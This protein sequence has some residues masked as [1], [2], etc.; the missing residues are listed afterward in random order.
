MTSIS[1]MWSLNKLSKLPSGS[2]GKAG[3]LPS[4]DDKPNNNI[5]QEEKKMKVTFQ[6]EKATKNTIRFEEALENALDAPKIGTL[7]VPKSTL[8]ELGWKEGKKLTVEVKL[9]K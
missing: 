9:E 6:M 7:Y 2:H 5:Q 4:D 3:N 8:A 1:E